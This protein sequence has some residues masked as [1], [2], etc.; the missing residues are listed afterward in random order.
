MAEFELINDKYGLFERHKCKC[1]GNLCIISES[2][3]D[4]CSPDEDSDAYEE[5]AEG[6]G[7]NRQA[8]CRDYCPYLLS[9]VSI[10][11]KRA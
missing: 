1:S 5:L 3:F 9:M 4:S 6:Y 8:Y 2:R 7:Y 11:I 10:L